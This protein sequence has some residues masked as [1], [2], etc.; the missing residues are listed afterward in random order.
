MQ[1][2]HG[3]L[4][5]KFVIATTETEKATVKFLW[6][7]FVYTAGRR[8]LLLYAADFGV[9]FCSIFSDQCFAA[10]ERRMKKA[11]YCNTLFTL[12]RS[13]IARRDIPRPPWRPRCP[14]PACGRRRR[15]RRAARCPPPGCWPAAAPAARAPSPPLAETTTATHTTVHPLMI[16]KTT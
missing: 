12:Y 16:I 14:G 10:A 11:F 6:D 2:R 4:L 1:S 5:M 7:L 15:R 3:S 8:H 9:Q 13:P